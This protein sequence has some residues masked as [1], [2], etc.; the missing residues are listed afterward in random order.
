MVG[1]CRDE[2][3]NK[4][5]HLPDP[6]NIYDNKFLH[7]FADK[8]KVDSVSIRQWRHDPNKH[9]Y[10]DKAMYS[11]SS[12]IGLHCYISSMMCRLFGYPNIT[13]FSVEWVPLIDVV[14][15]SY[16][17]DWATIP[18]NNISAQILAYRKKEKKKERK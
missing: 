3:L 11:I 12:I 10:D 15:Y 6:H 8:N 18:S 17:M 13:K 14:S 9:T 5:Y 7:N 1:S 4:M 2:E 16:I